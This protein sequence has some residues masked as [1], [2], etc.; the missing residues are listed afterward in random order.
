MLSAVLD[1]CCSCSLLCSTE[2]KGA[3]MGEKM[4][5]V[6]EA[7]AIML[8][9]ARRT[10]VVSV[11]VWQAA[12]RVLAGDVATD[13]DLSPF[14][15]SAMDGYAVRAED[16]ASACAD[17]PV[18][19][20]V[21][22]HEAAGHV[23]A[24]AVEPGTT[25]RIMTGA[26]VPPGA[27]AVVKYEVVA[28]CEG[29]GN[30]GSRVAFTAPAFV[31]ENIREAGLEAHRGEAVLHAGEVC[32]AAGCGLAASAGHETLSVYRAP[33]VGIISLG[34]ELVAPAVTPDRGQ[35][36]D[37]N[38]STLMAQALDAGAEPTFF[39]IAPDDEE[40]IA[41]LI[42]KAAQT[43]DLVITSGGASAGDYDYV[44]ALVHRE[45]Q[46][47]FDRVSMRPG[48]AITFGLL[49][50]TP[51]LGLSGNPAA[52]YVGFEMLARPMLRA[53]QGYPEGLRP[54][55]QARVTHN[56]SKRQERRFY[57]RASVARDA[58]TG[59]LTVTSATSQ[60]SA[61]LGTLH[62]ANCLLTVPDGLVGYAAGD[63]VEVVRID[64]PEGAVL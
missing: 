13:I 63:M 58:V 8:A 53:M 22:G 40:A 60:N 37:A 28:V 48:K 45:G 11:P 56:V 44:T 49:G 46:V 15:N 6:E 20:E 42:R 62:H 41:T 24:G 2:K 27:D 19:L 3:A 18:E 34:T 43:C 25:V 52:A 1:G 26:P 57:D 14:A 12:G 59:E 10:E 50:K 54:R 36:R 55:Q 7:Q 30:E 47:L 33:R 38:S 17:S 32:T 64:L 61:L 29:D 21:V 5:L 39:G 35:I 31:G 16:L 23:F 9:H 51:Y 4:L